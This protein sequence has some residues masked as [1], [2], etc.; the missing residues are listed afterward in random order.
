VGLK[1]LGGRLLGPY[2]PHFEQ[3]ALKSDTVSMLHYSPLKQLPQSSKFIGLLAT[4]SPAQK[5]FRPKH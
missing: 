1:K 4:G 3:G 2:Q 5:L